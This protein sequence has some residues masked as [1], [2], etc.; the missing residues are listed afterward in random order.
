MAKLSDA[1]YLRELLDIRDKLTDFVGQVSSGKRSYYKD[2][3]AKLRILYCRKS[4]S[5]PLLKTISDKF[6]FDILAAIRYTI[7]EKVERGVYPASLAEGLVFE[8]IN[9]VVTWFEG[10][11]EIAGVLEAVDRDE[12]LLN[13]NRYS[14]KQIIEVAADKMV[15]AHVD[16]GVKDE[17][18]A[19]H[20]EN[21]LIGGL[22]AAERAL[23]DTAKASILLINAIEDHLKN[24]TTYPF[25]RSK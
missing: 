1:G 19:L 12:V 24:G 18:L 6:N 15:G 8:Q 25:I 9:S 23:Y 10:G 21:L 3:S 20:S 13:G 2:I 17:D 7:Q 14:Y 16:P 5:D 4:S 11:D 22:P